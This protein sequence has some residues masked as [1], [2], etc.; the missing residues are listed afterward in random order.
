MNRKI[1]F[2]TIFST[3][4]LLLLPLVAV[5]CRMGDSLGP[6]RNRPAPYEEVMRGQDEPDL[7]RLFLLPGEMLDINSASAEELKALP[8]IGD[9]LSEAIVEYRTI[10]GDFESTEDV[11]DVEGIGP[12]RF[13]GMETQIYAGD[14]DEDTGS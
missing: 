13:E 5:L 4:L 1:L 9:E 6:V 11:M 3:V 8:G 12:G 10:H 14:T 7:P 2:L